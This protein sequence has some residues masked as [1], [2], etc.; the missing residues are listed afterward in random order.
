MAR[1]PRVAVIT[2]AGGGIGAATAAEFAAR[3][4]HVVLADARLDAAES[5]AE[6]LAQQHA[7]VMPVSVDVTDAASVAAMT[8]AALGRWGRID[9]LVNNAGIECAK[10]FLEIDLVEFE[11]VMRVNTTGTWLCCQSV[12][13][14]MLKRGG[15]AIVNISSV[16]AL[17]GGGF[18]G[19]SAYA[20]SKG[21]VIAL[22]KALAREFG[23]A[24]IRVNAVA[25]SF[26]LTDFVR[27]QLAQ[28]PAGTQ[29]KIVA[30]TP[31]GRAAQPE[32]SARVIAF[33]GS[34]DAS[35][36]T[37]QVYNVDGGVAM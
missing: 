32:E 13:P 1:E 9:T 19:T 22:T 17:R 34:D 4:A 35:F 10:D 8:E 26:T 33:L 14:S 16:A 27:R 23:P 6:H 24:G 29:E 7:E 5:V 3:G 37:G 31:L 30:A 18:L 28:K 2:G 36:V 15:G 21:A 25:P 20:T 12:L 11:R